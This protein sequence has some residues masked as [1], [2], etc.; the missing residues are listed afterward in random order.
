[1]ASLASQGSPLR[2][3]I[4]LRVV[5]VVVFVV[6]AVGMVGLLSFS[7]QVQNNHPSN[8]CVI[9]GQP[10]GMF[11]MIIS[12]NGGTAIPGVQVSAT[13]K[14]ADDYCNGV[15]YTGKITESSFTTNG[16]TRWYNLDSTNDGTYSISILYSG[17][18][19]SL[20]AQMR[21]VSVTC[22]VLYIPSGHSNVTI[23]EMKSTCS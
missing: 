19:Y 18:N 9:Q 5:T 6:F 12:D 23:S 3:R 20:V 10:A 13:H 1:M 11:F 21:P 15:L 7:A 16:T 17:R 2:R 22:A 14:E 4:G 8:P